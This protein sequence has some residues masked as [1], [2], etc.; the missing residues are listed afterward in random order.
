MS[1]TIRK[2]VGAAGAALLAFALSGPASAKTDA[3]KDPK[4]APHLVWAATYQAAL[5][6]AALRGTVI[7]ANFHIDH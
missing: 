6:E 1:R 4:N 2:S 7:F 5:D 3:A